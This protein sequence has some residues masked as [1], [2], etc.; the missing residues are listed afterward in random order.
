MYSI[1]TILSFVQYCTLI[2]GIPVY[3][4][5]HTGVDFLIMPNDI[6]LMLSAI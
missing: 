5:Y 6:Q 3:I 1:D 4:L 2:G